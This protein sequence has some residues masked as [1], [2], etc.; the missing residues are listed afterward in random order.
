MLKHEEFLKEDN[1]E[2]VPR[3]QNQ[4]IESHSKLDRVTG[5]T[6]FTSINFA[7]WEN[8]FQMSFDEHCHLKCGS[9]YAK[10]RSMKTQQQDNYL[11]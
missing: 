8:A 3:N 2:S 10:K 9:I 7:I 4:V 5:F 6:F 1:R 11:M